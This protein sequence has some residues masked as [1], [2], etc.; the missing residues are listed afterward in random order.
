MADDPNEAAM[1]STQREAQEALEKQVAQLKRE[2]SKINRTLAERAEE[3]VEEATGWYE[4]AADSASRT[5]QALRNRAS[6]VSG[7]VQENPGT[8]SSAFILGAAVGLLLG[9]VLVAGDP[10]RDR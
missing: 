5:T 7:A 1:P 8:V 6:T 10:R 3:V 4:S 9:L 2:I